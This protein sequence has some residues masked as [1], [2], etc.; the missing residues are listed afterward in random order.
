MKFWKCWRTD[1]HTHARTPARA[2]YY[3]LTLSLQLWWANKYTAQQKFSTDFNT[4]FH[5]EWTWTISFNVI[6]MYG[7]LEIYGFFCFRQTKVIW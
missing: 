3:K 6:N 2:P 1:G 4:M 7:D 5:F